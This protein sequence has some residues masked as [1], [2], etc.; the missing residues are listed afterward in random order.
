MA[1]SAYTGLPGHGKSY[2]LCA[3]VIPSALSIGRR[4][5]TNVAGINDD[6]I[7]DFLEKKGIHV[8]DMG[9]IIHVTN[10]QVDHD[11]FYY[12]EENGK[13][14]GESTVK[15]GDL[16]ILDEAW[17]WFENGTALTKRVKNFLRYHRH[18]VND[19]NIA[20]DII[21][22]TQDISDLNRSVRSLIEETYVMTKLK[23]LGFDNSY[24][25][26]VYYRTKVGARYKPKHSEVGRFQKAFFAFYSSYEFKKDQEGKE[27]AGRL[28]IEKKVDKRG[29]IWNN[30]FFKYAMPSAFVA[31][32]FFSYAIYNFF[33]DPDVVS[34]FGDP[35]ARE[36]LKADN[37][38]KEKETKKDAKGFVIPPPPP[39][40]NQPPQ[41]NQVAQQ[42]SQPVQGQP[43]TPPK[44]PEPKEPK[45][46]EKVSVTGFYE[47]G[48][49]L[50]VLL[51]VGDKT[52]VLIN[53][54]D[55][56]KKDILRMEGMY[57]GEIVSTYTGRS[58]GVMPVSNSS[59]PSFGGAVMDAAKH[60]VT[61]PPAPN[62]QPH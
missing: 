10:E 21:F 7:Y 35:Q 33:T 15:P 50:Y 17:K 11:S 18:Y 13:P 51:K 22:V 59:Q 45:E 12:Y 41:P 46:S 38:K 8:D 52:R 29:V 36:K 61:S 43:Q 57:Q 44:P 24:R 28:G 1:I 54:K 25:V 19:K 5:I 49:D 47:V 27:V 34:T 58:A 53:P 39:M 2:Q 56:T 6:V 14:V 37:E 23:E 32:I 40:P 62:S 48:K 4:V 42:S 31:F 60:P 55:F 16:V 26:D 30:K 3:V 9:E 20:C